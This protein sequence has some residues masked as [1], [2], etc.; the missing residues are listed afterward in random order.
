MIIKEIMVRTVGIYG[1]SQV[2]AM[3][4]DPE[5]YY[6]GEWEKIRVVGIGTD[7]KTPLEV[8]RS[9]VGLTIPTIFTKQKI[10]EQVRIT[11]PIPE[12]SRLAYSLDVIN[13]LRNVGKNDVAAQL[14]TI[15]P[16]YLDMYVFE[17][18]ICEHVPWSSS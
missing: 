6:I 13:A 12:G 10:E 17:K 3:F 1:S 8:R 14:E 18:E 7:E 16:N 15:S 4:G 9:L 11:L 5:T 2:M